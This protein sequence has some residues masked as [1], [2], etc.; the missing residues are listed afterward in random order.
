MINQCRSLLETHVTEWGLPVE[1]DWTFLVYNNYNPR[2]SNLNIFWF[3]QHQQ[4]PLVMT[5]V[6][7]EASLP[8]QE[9]QNLQ[10]VYA[11]AAEAVP[12]PLG[13]YQQD[14]FWTLWMTAVPGSRLTTDLLS[15]TAID[16]FSDALARI[17]SGV[18]GKRSPQPATSDPGG[19]FFEAAIQRS[20]S[21]AANC[22]RIRAEYT[23]SWLEAMPKLPQ[24]GDLY[25]DHILVGGSNSWHIVDWETLGE[26]DLPYYDVITLLLSLAGEAPPRAWNAGLERYGRRLLAR[27]SKSLQ[28]A[29]QDFLRLL[30]LILARWA[31]AQ[32][33]PA[34][35]SSA[36]SVLEDYFSHAREWE[37]ALLA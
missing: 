28:L 9:F 17:H 36:Y 22:R 29:P 5:K 3:Q 7:P 30:P 18:A 10:D 37:Q 24:H 12:R 16:Q 15:D 27:Y 34:R 21:L 35:E 19:D 32:R 23:Q 20:E 4:T 31:R 11:Y 2:Y 26:I 8:S 13:L 6:F 1:R 14:D 25:T 33:S